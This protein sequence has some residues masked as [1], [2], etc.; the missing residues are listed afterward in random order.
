MALLREQPATTPR[1]IKA[2]DF[3]TTGAIKPGDRGHV[4]VEF[5]VLPDKPATK[6]ELP[7]AVRTTFSWGFQFV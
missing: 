6:G 5:T 2:G 4:E 3:N 7:V 1:L